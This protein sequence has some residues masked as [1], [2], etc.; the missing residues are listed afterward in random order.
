MLLRRGRIVRVRTEQE[1]DSALGSSDQVIVEGDDRLL[2]YAVAK[3]SDDAQNRIDV[4]VEGGSISVG[5]DALKPGLRVVAYVLPLLVLF[6]ASPVF[7]YYL[8][9]AGRNGVP[10]P[11]CWLR[12]F[13]RLALTQ[14]GN[15]PHYVKSCS[16][17]RRRLRTRYGRGSL[18]FDRASRN[19]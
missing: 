11:D 14:S 18:A 3:A 2:S 19:S 7:F 6:V 16:A 17:G 15:K 10:R 5:P 9:S 1:F 4:E 8:G 12:A 13:W